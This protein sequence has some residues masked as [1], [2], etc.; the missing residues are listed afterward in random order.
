VARASSAEITISQ[1]Q[2]TILERWVR[3]K[4]DT[5]YRLIERS[6]IVLMSADGVNNAE[7][8]RHLG[9]DRQRIRRWRLRWRDAEQRLAEAEGKNV[10]DKDLARLLADILDD[11][12]RSGV[13]P[14]FTAETLTQIIALAC[15]PPEDSDRPV[16]HWT[17]RELA[18]EAIKRGIVTSI[19][20]RHVDRLLKGGISDRI[21]PVIG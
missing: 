10:S 18:D 13:P 12:E 17:P 1:R 9:V 11:S 3:N 21:R 4:A 8:G 6:Q 20:P 2:R 5:P 16:T 15:E 14:T 19:S 7:Q